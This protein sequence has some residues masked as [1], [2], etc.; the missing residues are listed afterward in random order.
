MMSGT[1]S[2]SESCVPSAD[3]S[4][5][6]LTAPWSAATRSSIVSN[7]SLLGRN[8]STS[9][10]LAF[11]DTCSVSWTSGVVPS[12]NTSGVGVDVSP[13]SRNAG[14]RLYAA[15]GGWPSETGVLPGPLLSTKVVFAVL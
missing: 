14:S 12:L 5:A 1:P 9:P 10:L 4:R 6:V 2:P 13:S 11:V 3:W 7:E 15:T 8:T